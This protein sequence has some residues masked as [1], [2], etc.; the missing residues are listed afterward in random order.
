M[1]DMNYGNSAEGYTLQ[2]GPGPSFSSGGGPNLDNLFAM[3]AKK[4]ADSEAER[5][6]QFLVDQRHQEQME[7]ARMNQ[8]QPQ[9][10][11]PQMRQEDMVEVPQQGLLAYQGGQP[12]FTQN[13]RANS[14]AG[15]RGSWS[16]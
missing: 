7:N 10:G 13:V 15:Q 8:M 3:M 6:R 9:G 16:M 4:K 1:P 11:P 12:G 2:T 14:L 5:R